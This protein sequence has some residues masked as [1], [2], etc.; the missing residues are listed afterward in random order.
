MTKLRTC[1]GAAIALSLLL[2]VA[3]CGTVRGAAGAATTTAPPAQPLVSE[4]MLGL[5]KLAL[6]EADAAEFEAA[7]AEVGANPE[8]DM[9]RMMVEMMESLLLS[10]ELEI[11]PGSMNMRINMGAE[12]EQAATAVTFE[13][14]ADGVDEATIVTT[15][16]DGGIDTFQVDFEGERMRWSNADDGETI[17]WQRKDTA[18]EDI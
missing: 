3:G 7:R 10:S 5:W 17:L 4:R 2:P 9:A 16:E 12:G 13:V 1:L 8:D 11:E 15:D 6:S 14:T 18:A